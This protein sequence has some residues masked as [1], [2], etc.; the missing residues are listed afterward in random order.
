M[1]SDEPIK[2]LRDMQR[3]N[4]ESVVKLIAIVKRTPR[5]GA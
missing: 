4:R 2:M 3:A 1:A 5:L